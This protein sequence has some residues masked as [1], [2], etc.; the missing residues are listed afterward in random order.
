VKLA[1][2]WNRRRLDHKSG[3]VLVNFDWGWTIRDE[4]IPGLI[5]DVIYRLL[6]VLLGRDF[7]VAGKAIRPVDST[8]S[9]LPM[10]AAKFPANPAAPPQGPIRF[11]PQSHSRASKCPFESAISSP[12][13]IFLSS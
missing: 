12:D 13:P 11:T 9:A 8:H 6:F 1:V 3:A 4:S 2:A 5:I 7:G 10:L